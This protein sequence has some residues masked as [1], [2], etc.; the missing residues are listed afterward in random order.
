MLSGVR[1]CFGSGKRLTILGGVRDNHLRAHAANGL[2]H[3][4][5]PDGEVFGVFTSKKATHL[6]AGTS[7]IKSLPVLLSRITEKGEE[8]KCSL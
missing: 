1:K 7:K 8:T 6:V 2:F 3:S 4:N 5:M